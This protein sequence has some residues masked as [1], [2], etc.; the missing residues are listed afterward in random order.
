MYYLALVLPEEI[1]KK[2]LTLK[3]MMLERFECR[4]GLKSPAHIT[5]IPPF[6]MEPGMEENFIRDTDMLAADL[7]PFLLQTRDF[8]CFKPRT[9]FIDVA[10]NVE[11][12]ESKKKTD[13]FFSERKHYGLKIENRA[14]HPHITI[15]TRDLHKKTFY[16][17]WALF[18]NKSFREECLI[19][20][21]SVLRHNQKNWDVIHTS[22]FKNL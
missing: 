6:W 2:V 22:Q 10:P 15:A 8:S 17:A 18:E 13:V 4:V 3:Q 16:E 5:L 12:Q 9:L 21:L 1:N 20:G 11:L 19:D 7:K 14:F